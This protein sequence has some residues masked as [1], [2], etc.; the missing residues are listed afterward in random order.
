MPV[1]FQRPI[2][3]GGE[4]GVWQIE[5]GED[6]FRRRLA[7]TAMERRQLDSMHAG[8]RLQW[9]AARQLVHR[10]SG[11]KERGAFFKDEFGKP[12][13]E[14]S[15]H[16]VS[17]SHSR[18][19][20]AAIAAPRLVGIDIQAYVEKIGRLAGKYMAPEELKSL[21]QQHRLEQ[22]HVYWC[23][24]EALYKAHGRRQLNFCHH[25]RVEAFDYSSSGGRFQAWI[26]KGRV[27]RAFDLHYEVWNA[28]FLVYAIARQA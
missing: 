6:W 11:R 12:H 7:L 3:H 22:L 15:T 10:M 4:L 25:L 13:L 20:A 16:Q 18:E 19:L 21:N 23:A 28:H 17:I 2:E 1:L 27:P 9:L 24:K 5:E 26:T 8:R 14:A